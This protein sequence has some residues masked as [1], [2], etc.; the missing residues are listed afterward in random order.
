MEGCDGTLDGR[1]DELTFRR[2]RRFASGGAKLLWFEATAVTPEGRANPR[3]LWIHQRSVR[4]FARLLDHLRQEHR[5]R[6]ETTDDL[7]EPLQLTHS[8]RYSH[9][10]RI[11]ACHSPVVDR[12]T[13]VA[14]DLSII[15]DGELERL[16]DC[17]VEAARLGLAAGFRAVD[18]KAT[19]GYLLNEL[20]GA[21]NRPGAYG[22]SLENRTRFIR[23][24][25]GK[26]RA[27]LGS[28][29]I[30]CM[31]LGVFEGVPY[32]RD[33]ATGLG[34]PFEYPIPYPTG[35]GVDPNNPLL[36][37]L[38]EVR[39]AIG[40]F[41]EWGIQLLNVSMGTPYFNPHV[42]RPFEKPDEGNYE[43]PEHPLLG[44]ERH[45]RIAGELQRTFPDLPMVGTG[46]SWL[47]KYCVNA[48]ARNIADGQIRVMGIGRG[49]LAYPDFAHDALEQGELDEQRVCKT[50]TY[51]TYLMRRKDNPLGQW[52][53]GCPPFD[54]EGYGEIMKQARATARL[55][56]PI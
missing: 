55:H 31:R 4:E 6:Y 23:N 5:E 16:E 17:Y 20:L 46:Y 13:G 38:T 53:T 33:P 35:F 30:L 49:A 47:Q 48:G 10:T 15:S 27:A 29:L 2:Y 44:V 8:G 39:Q 22:G 18:I 21:R 43:P 3:Q 54:K 40:W 25:I 45:F 50:L 1:P 7:L 14:A 52:P 28:Q 11:I 26:I 32:M 37:D 19:H 24:V 36:E 34:V 9:P 51:C 56:H 42:G 12:K 41:R